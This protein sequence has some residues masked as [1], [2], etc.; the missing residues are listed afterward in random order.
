MAKKEQA[1]K[2]QIQAPKKIEQSDPLPGSEWSFSHPPPERQMYHWLNYEYSTGDEELSHQLLPLVLGEREHPGER[3][4]ER[5]LWIV[6]HPGRSWW[7]REGDPP[8]SSRPSFVAGYA[9][10][11]RSSYCG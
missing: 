10:H 1:A 11:A 3:D 9:P 6:I 7:H 4:G 5:F 2:D 8:K